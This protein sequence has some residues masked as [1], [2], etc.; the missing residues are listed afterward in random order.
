[1]IRCHLSTLMGCH[2]LKIADVS[3]ETGLNR[4]TVTALYH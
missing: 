1:M 3:R 4:S 2:K